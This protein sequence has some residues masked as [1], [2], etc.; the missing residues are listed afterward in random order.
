MPCADDVDDGYADKGTTH[1]IVA[2]CLKRCDAQD[3]TRVG[4]CARRAVDN[5]I[6]SCCASVAMFGRRDDK[7][8]LCM[9]TMVN[10]YVGLRPDESCVLCARR[11]YTFANRTF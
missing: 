9:V 10:D 5:K 6:V 2:V 11:V 1:G 3:Q 4:G 8:V 7:A